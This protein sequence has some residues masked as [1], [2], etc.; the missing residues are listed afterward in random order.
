MAQQWCTVPDC[1]LL[2]EFT[3]ATLLTQITLRY[4]LNHVTERL[5]DDLDRN[6]LTAAVRDEA[7]PEKLA[8]SDSDFTL[9]DIDVVTKSRDRAVVETEMR[10]QIRVGIIVCMIV[11]IISYD[12]GYCMFEMLCLLKSLLQQTIFVIIVLHI[13]IGNVMQAA[14]DNAPVNVTS[15]AINS[16]G[17]PG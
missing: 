16:V 2:T 5:T 11:L 8:S 3:V 4:L 6:T 14:I 12:I 15:C 1:R 10:A 7:K 13:E 17:V 9:S